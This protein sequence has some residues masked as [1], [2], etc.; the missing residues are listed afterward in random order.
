[1]QGMMGGMM[2]NMW[3]WTIAGIRSPDQLTGFLVERIKA[4]GSRTL[5]A[6]VCSDAT[7]DD[8]VLVDNGRGGAAV[9][10][11]EPAELLH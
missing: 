6:P 7:S 11:R 1:M 9:G 2:A 5:R 3:V 8:Q 4:I 10:K